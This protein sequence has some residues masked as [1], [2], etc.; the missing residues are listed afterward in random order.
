MADSR[1]LSR[2][3]KQMGEAVARR[4]DARREKDKATGRQRKSSEWVCPQ[5]LCRTS[6]FMMH[7]VCRTCNC[8]GTGEEHPYRQQQQRQQR[9][10][11]V[12]KQVA[13]DEV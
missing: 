8:P 4:R 11:E 9:Q 10:E 2:G 1:Q 13:M 7:K 3:P 12:R 5:R 6:N